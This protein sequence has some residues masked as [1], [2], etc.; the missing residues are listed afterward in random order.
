MPE[1]IRVFCP[2]CGQEHMYEGAHGWVQTKEKM[3]CQKCRF[4]GYF[5]RKRPKI[6]QQQPQQLDEE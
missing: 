3:Q 6:E 4:Q 5:V 1:K 2:S